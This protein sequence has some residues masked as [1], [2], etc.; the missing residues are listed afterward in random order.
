MKIFSEAIRNR[1]NGF[2]SADTWN[3]FTGGGPG[4]QQGAT[5][6]GYPGGGGMGYPGG[7]GGYPGGGP[8][9]ALLSCNCLQRP[10]YEYVD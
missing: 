3:K 6:G 2:P 4:P 10:R 9:G 7:Q 8:G 1:N 5:G